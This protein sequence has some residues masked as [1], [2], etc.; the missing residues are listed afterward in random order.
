MSTQFTYYVS[1]SFSRFPGGRKRE[2]GPHSGQEFWETVTEP[3]LDKYDL[4]VFDLTGGTAYSSGFLDE[5]FGELGKVIGL[6]EAKRRITIRADDDELAV[7]TAWRRIKD[8]A[9]EAKKQ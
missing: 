8:A 5:A 2:N 7:Q 6:A 4:I 3:L 9:E 1:K